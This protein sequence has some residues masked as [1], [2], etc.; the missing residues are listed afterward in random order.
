[1]PLKV[2]G[3]KSAPA[4]ANPPDQAQCPIRM[5]G[6]PSPDILGKASMASVQAS[7]TPE[8]VTRPKK[9][10]KAVADALARGASNVDLV[11][12]TFR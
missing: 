8:Q 6:Y 9:V 3:G 1:M 12:R 10:G 5:Q 4:L 11:S 2:A 7:S